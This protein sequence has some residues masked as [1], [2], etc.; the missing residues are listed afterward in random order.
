M[1]ITALLTCCRHQKPLVVLESSPFN[2]FEIRPDDLREMARQLTVIADAAE[3]PV[4]NKH[5]KHIR[6]SHTWGM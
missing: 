5:W 3:Q 6:I 1:N 4:E 2:G